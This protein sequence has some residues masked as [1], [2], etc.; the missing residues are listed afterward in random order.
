MFRTRL[1]KSTSAQYMSGRVW[2]TTTQVLDNSVAKP[3]DR[4]A[5]RGTGGFGWTD[6]S[7]RQLNTEIMC[8][9]WN[10]AWKLRK[11]AFLC[12]RFFLWLLLVVLV[13]VLVRILEKME[14][15]EMTTLLVAA[16]T[17]S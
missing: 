9:D 13:A 6:C 12:T 2:I 1:P 17:V 4:L 7:I 5:R 16:T 8:S 10:K 15:N 11:G 3:V 14:G